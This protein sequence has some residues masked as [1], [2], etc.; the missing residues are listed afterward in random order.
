MFRLLT[1]LF[2]NNTCSY[3]FLGKGVYPIL[4]R[5]ANKKVATSRIGQ[6]CPTCGWEGNRRSGVTLVTDL[7]WL[8]YLRTRGLTKGSRWTSHQPTL[9]I[10]YGTIY[11][12]SLYDEFKVSI[13]T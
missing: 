10:G 6:R 5:P 7:K 4:S 11:P 1:T 3:R 9:F 13:S 8:I 2:K 12:S